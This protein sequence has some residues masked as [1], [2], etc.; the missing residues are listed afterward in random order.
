MKQ[1]R[2][3]WRSCTRENMAA[4]DSYFEVAE[5]SKGS[6]SGHTRMTANFTHVSFFSS[7]FHEKSP[8]SSGVKTGHP[9]KMAS[10]C[11]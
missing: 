6:G 1:L 3:V 8:H 9:L 11:P 5:R 10:G 7:F 2:E 4:D